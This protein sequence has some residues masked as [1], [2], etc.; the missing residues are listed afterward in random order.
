MIPGTQRKS[1]VA[2]VLWIAATV[3][4]IGSGIVGL[5]LALPDLVWLME[6]G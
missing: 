4:L 1:R 6:R 5:L 3:L 2:R